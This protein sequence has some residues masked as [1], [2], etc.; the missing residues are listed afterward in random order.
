MELEFRTLLATLTIVLSWAF[1]HTMFALHYAHEFYDEN[2]GR[3]GGMQFPG[4]DPEPDYW[5]FMYFSV[6][7]NMTF[8]VSDVQISSRPI[9][10]LALLHGVVAFFFNVTII[11]I[12]VNVAAGILQ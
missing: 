3:G 2:Q 7:L 11:A 9:R 5:D 10:R 8:Q 6:V 1:T 12:T 4:D